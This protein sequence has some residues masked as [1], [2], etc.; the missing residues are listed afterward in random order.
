MLLDVV[1][2]VVVEEEKTHEEVGRIERVERKDEATVV[3]GVS[4]YLYD[5]HLTACKRGRI[6]TTGEVKYLSALPK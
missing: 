2:D 3:G 4:P 5:N 1:V 6:M